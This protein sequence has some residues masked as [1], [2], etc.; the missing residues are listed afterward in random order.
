MSLVINDTSYHGTRASGYWMP[1]VFSANTISQ[2][3]VNI[4]DG[5]KDKINIGTI[6]FAGGLQPRN[7]KP[8]ESYG[9]WSVDNK[10][11]TPNAAM[12][13]TE[14]WPGELEQHWESVKLSTYMLER[15]LPNEFES[16]IMQYM[17]AKVFG[18]QMEVGWWMSSENY[19]V[20]TD[21]TDSRYNY[22]FCDGFMKR[23][24]DD[25]TTLTYA[26]PATITT[27]NVVTFMDG[28]I[29][30]II[31]NKQGLLERQDRMV[32]LMNRK[33]VDIWRK[34]M[35]AA[36]FKGIN[37]LDKVWYEYAGYRIKVCNGI[38]NDTILF[39]EFT[40][41]FDSALHIGFNAAG[42]E[43]NIQMAKTRPM[44]ETYFIKALMKFN[45][46]IKYANEIAMVTL[47]TSAD[48]TV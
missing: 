24:V 2:G 10:V 28:L 19:Q 15:K 8:S 33:T 9:Q 37:Y 35:V 5:V 22:Q 3:V 38:P 34:A 16:Y 46:Q 27:S 14:F 20:I 26:S 31:A 7:I 41:D 25:S 48:F 32:F 43:T 47:L 29:S 17:M 39:G 23:L 44:D 4:M 42:D 6:D 36:T 45:T 18:Q 21:K 30:L 40:S 13:Y 1:S 12:L 11:L